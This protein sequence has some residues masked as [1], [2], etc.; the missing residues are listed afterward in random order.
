MKRIVSV[1][2]CQTTIVRM[3]SNQQ[4]GINLLNLDESTVALTM[5][6]T[7]NHSQYKFR[8]ELD[9]S[10]V[11]TTCG[12]SSVKAY[13]SHGRRI[14]KPLILGQDTWLQ[15]NMSEGYCMIKMA[16]Q[17][18]Q[19]YS[20]ILLEIS[21]KEHTHRELRSRQESPYR[22]I[23]QIL[24]FWTFLWNRCIVKRESGS[25]CSKFQHVWIS[26]ANASG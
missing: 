12:S 22:V 24:L 15:R 8:R 26:F 21:N 17:W 9:W 19:T 13:F 6:R 16:V 25:C 23:F 1:C 10:F 7:L 11:P 18:R 14:T 3:D 4:L 2:T 20:H 5:R